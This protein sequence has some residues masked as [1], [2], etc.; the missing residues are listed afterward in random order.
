MNKLLLPLLCLCLA[1]WLFGGSIWFGEQYAK[2]NQEQ[3]WT[4]LDGQE[5]FHS[6]TIFSFQVSDPDIILD[7]NQL[8][9]ISDISQYLTE[10]K[11]RDLFIAGNYTE[12]EINNSEYSNLGLARAE[13]FRYLFYRQGIDLDRINTKGKIVQS[14]ALNSNGLINGGV[15]I[16]FVE[17]P[18]VKYGPDFSLT[19]E[20]HFKAT[21]TTALEMKNFNEYVAAVRQYLVDYPNKKIQLTGYYKTAEQEGLARK[22]VYN[23]E[24]NLVKTGVASEYLTSTLEASEDIQTENSYVEISIY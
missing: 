22:R 24:Q 2:S 20:I 14:H 11:E 15:S 19:K 12:K 4:I 7:D 21:S 23:L 8:A 5:I 1:V 6:S 13:S 10:H 9:M 17:S 3:T 16:S 18:L